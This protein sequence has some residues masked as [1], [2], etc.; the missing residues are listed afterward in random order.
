MPLKPGCPYLMPRAVFPLTDIKIKNSK[1]SEKSYK[2]FDGGGL[3]V[4]ITPSGGKLW[5]IK[6]NSQGK[7]TRLSFGSYPTVSLADARKKDKKCRNVKAR[8]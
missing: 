2:L 6:L 5:R 8:E 3:Y 1:P 7:E 4:E